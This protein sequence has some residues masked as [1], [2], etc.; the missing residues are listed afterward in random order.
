VSESVQLPAII[1]PPPIRPVVFVGMNCPRGNPPFWPR[2]SGS[3]GHRLWRLVEDAVGW[4]ADEFVERTERLHFVEGSSWDMDA[5]RAR[6]A[7]VRRALAGRRTI[8]VGRV[9]ARLLEAPEEPCV[10]DDGLAYL[11]HTAG[12]HR[13]Y[14]DDANRAL[15][16]AFLREALS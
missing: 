8:A 16:V 4:P 7:G 12:L 14:N 6:L 5:A 1:P 11:P 2:P 9:T 3:A 13:W 15:A 10:W